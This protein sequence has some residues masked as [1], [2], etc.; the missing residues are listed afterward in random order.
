MNEKTFFTFLILFSVI[1]VLGCL[2]GSS[3]QIGPTT[4]DSQVSKGNINA[5]ITINGKATT[6][7]NLLGEQTAEVSMRIKNAGTVQMKNL[8]TAV[9]GCLAL[10]SE[11][12]APEDVSPGSSTYLSWTLKAPEMGQGEQINCQV[13]LRTCYDYTTD[14]YI[15][16]PVANE[17][18]K[19]EISEP[20][21][22][23]RSDVLSVTPQIGILRV[24]KDQNTY[25]S[26]MAVTNIGP[27][28]VDY[29]QYIN[30]NEMY[31]LE[32]INLTVSKNLRFDSYA[33][34]S[35]EKLRD[36]GWLSTDNKTLTINA[37][38]TQADFDPT[39]SGSENYAYLLKMVGGK[40]LTLNFNLGADKANYPDIAYE[41]LTY[42][43]QHGYCTDVA[44]ITAHL[45]GT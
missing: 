16:I 7:V 37:A 15:E 39:I 23:T 14:G 24:I 5:S 26:K 25:V 41:R 2:G 27:G 33:G 31:K 30:G 43:L 20:S 3:G 10:Q 12:P 21:A 9:I 18:Y 22:F 6:D 19:E 44:T 1:L 4:T 45:S 28:W 35:A 17:N 13:I 42:V 38:N 11:K 32:K 40:E 29:L 34:F 8:E 36:A